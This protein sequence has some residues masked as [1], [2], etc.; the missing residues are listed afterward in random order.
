MNTGLCTI[1][2]LF[3]RRESG[4]IVSFNKLERLY[5]LLTNSILSVWRFNCHLEKVYCPSSRQPRSQRV[6]S[7]FLMGR[8]KEKLGTRLYPRESSTAHWRSIRIGDREGR[9]FVSCSGRSDY[10]K[11]DSSTPTKGFIYKFCTLDSG[12][13]TF[14]I[15]DVSENLLHR[16]RILYVTNK[17]NSV[18]NRSGLI[19]GRRLLLWCLL[20]LVRRCLV[21]VKGTLSRGM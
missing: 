2:C 16:I 11:V 8:R 7:Y 20:V 5:I 14:R 3:I 4:F 6:S 19:S 18:L 15:C 9:M 12:F 17:A 1:L 21:F 13:K 10:T